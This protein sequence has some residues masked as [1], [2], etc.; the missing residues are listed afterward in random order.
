MK[1][2]NDK[3]IRFLQKA[4]NNEPIAKIAA[5]LQRSEQSIRSKVNIMRRKGL[6]F[7]RVRD[8]K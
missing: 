5:A 2:W 8:K 3:E 4:Y 1:T 6:S 7:D